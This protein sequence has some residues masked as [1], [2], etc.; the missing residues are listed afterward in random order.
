MAGLRVVIAPDSFKGSMTAPEAA[1]AMARGW[2]VARPDDE[3]I[4]IPMADGGEGTLDIVHQA[5]PGSEV[6]SIGL[7]TGPGGHPTPGHYLKLD[8]RHALVELAVSSG[9]TLMDPLDALGATSMGLGETIRAALADGM[10]RITV[11]LGGSAS[12]DGGIGAL[13]ALGL[14]VTTTSGQPLPLG[15]AALSTIVA[16]D[17]SLLIRPRGGMVV[18]RDT[19]AT[20][21]EAPSVFGP[22]KGATLSD[23]HLL[24]KGLAHVKTLSRD[25]GHFLEPGSGAAG[26]AGWGLAHFLGGQLRD[27]AMEVGNLVGLEIAIASSDIV[28]TGEGRFDRTS[29]TGKV[30]GTIIEWGR[31]H[32]KPVGVV[33]GSAEEGNQVPGIAVASLLATAGSVDRAL[34]E[35]S[36]WAENATTELAPALTEALLWG[37]I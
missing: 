18:L 33:C 34:S 37:G 10:E 1:Q 28:V 20:L 22:Q 6:V 19:T 3:I 14:E 36:K 9:I 31:R 11:A 7:V 5:T 13:Q 26:G 8:D 35:A 16:V 21:L 23:I 32:G 15:G 17:T 27:G 4:S 25:T 24:E 2:Q 30:T 29:H 12:T